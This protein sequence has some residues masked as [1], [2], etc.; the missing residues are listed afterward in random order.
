MVDIIGKSNGDLDVESDEKSPTI[1]ANT[2]DLEGH[3][4]EL[5][6]M[7]EVAKSKIVK[8]IL[9]T[10]IFSHIEEIKIPEL[11]NAKTNPPENFR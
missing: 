8:L 11:N 10:V 5:E 9:P 4:S 6:E 1:Q 2:P 7:H 3:I